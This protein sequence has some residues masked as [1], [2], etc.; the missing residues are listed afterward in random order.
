MR[1]IASPGLF[2]TTPLLPEEF[3]YQPDIVSPH[4]EEQLLRQIESLPFKEF[5]F[6]GFLGKRRVVSFGWRYSYT[7][8]ELQQA[9]DIPA[10]LLPLRQRAAAFAHLEPADL[11]HV[12]VTEYRPGAAIG[13]H[14]DKAV[15]A[16]VIGV[17]LLSACRFRFRRKQGNAWQRADLITE[18]RSVY[19]L[20][21]SSRTE[22][23]HSIPPVERLRYSVTFRRSSK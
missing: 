7:K 15:F 19:L 1:R 13:W 11:Q 16:E 10:F 17:S 4:E 5:E 23:E 22:W 21:G 3:Q 8:H 20:A 12:L 9:M 18:P 2:E 14:R 6:H